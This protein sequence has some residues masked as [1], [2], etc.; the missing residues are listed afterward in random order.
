MNTYKYGFFMLML[1]VLGSCSQP[2]SDMNLDGNDSSIQEVQTKKAPG[3]DISKP[4]KSKFITEGGIQP[5]PESVE[6]CGLP[7][8]FYNVQDGGGEATH[9]GN[10]EIH[11]TFCV[12]AT[13]LLDD[14]QLTEGESIPY[15]SNENT[16]GYMIAANGDVLY[17]EIAEG[18]ILPADV[19]G[20]NFMFMDPF[21]FTGGTGRFEG[22]SG[23][24]T[25]YSLVNADPQQTEH[26]WNGVLNIPH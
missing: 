15:F 5:G 16:E 14:G 9:L 17:I 26:I 6:R 19:E 22:A 20:Y 11:I 12:D 24:G 10:F 13:D 4:F 8:F 3:D 2:T 21:I 18:E 7:P 25:T 1:L 23:S